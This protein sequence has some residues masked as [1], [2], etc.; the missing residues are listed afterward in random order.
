MIRLRCGKRPASGS[1][2]IGISLSDGAG[3]G[4]LV[5]ELVVLGRIDAAPGRWPARRWSGRPP[6]APRGGRRRRSPAPGPRRPSGRPGPATVASRSAIRSP[7]GVHRR[8]P[9]RAIASWSPGSIVPSDVEQR[10][11]VGDVLERGGG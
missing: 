10:R 2:R 6:S 5:G 4:D 7:Y 11:R 1:W 8:E 3:G 9:T